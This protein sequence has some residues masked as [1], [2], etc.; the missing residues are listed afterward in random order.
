MGLS[1]V[2]SMCQGM[3]ETNKHPN[4]WIGANPSVGQIQPPTLYPSIKYNIP[5]GVRSLHLAH[6][7]AENFHLIQTKADHQP[8]KEPSK[9][10]FI[11]AP[12]LRAIKTR[13]QYEW[14]FQKA[15]SKL[16]IHEPI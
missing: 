15:V 9:T 12:N 7:H 13:P 14:V 3:S 1:P 8:Q 10:P 4:C 5:E 6:W 11:L 16:T 2:L